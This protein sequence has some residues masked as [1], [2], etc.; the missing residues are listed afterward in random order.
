[1]VLQNLKDAY[2]HVPIYPSHW[3]LLR[4]A[5]MNAEGGLIVY[6]WK[7]LPF[8]LVTTP[9]VST[10]SRASV[11]AHLHLQGSASFP[12]MYPYIDNSFHA[13][14][15]MSHSRNQSPLL[16]HAELHCQPRKVGLVPSQVMLHLGAMM[17]MAGGFCSPLLPGG[18]QS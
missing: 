14:P 17:N 12:L 8:G 5:L 9:R 7:V 18:G 10:K 6:Q 16:L 11:A 1:M 4:F 13:P 15:G 3:R 2:L